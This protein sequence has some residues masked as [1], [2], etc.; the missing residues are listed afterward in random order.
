[1][2]GV[3]PQRHQPVASVWPLVLGTVAFTLGSVL[4]VWTALTAAP[5]AFIGEVR[6]PFAEVSTLPLSV[7]GYLLT[8]F[9]VFVAL[10]WD[11]IGQRLGLRDRNFGLKPK[12]TRAL[13]VMAILAMVLAV[14]HVLNISYAVAGA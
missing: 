10:V 1:M 11:R 12:Y 5:Q 6:L 13:Q 8:P 2:A 7:G 14:W 9:V 4:G 3:P